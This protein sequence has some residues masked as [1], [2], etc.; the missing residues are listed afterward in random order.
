MGNGHWAKMRS[1][2]APT[3]VFVNCDEKYYSIQ[4]FRQH[5]SCPNKFW[6]SKTFFSKQ[7]KQMLS[8]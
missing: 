7:E 1:P 2:G 6:K 5:Q 3:I 4:Y 8:Q